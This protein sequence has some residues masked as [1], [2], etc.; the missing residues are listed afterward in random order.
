[1]GRGLSPATH[2]VIWPIVTRPPERGPPPAKAR[3]RA[4]SGSSGRPPQP[5]TYGDRSESIGFARRAR[6][7]IPPFLT[8]QHSFAIQS[9]P[10]ARPATNARSSNGSSGSGASGSSGAAARLSIS[11]SLGGAFR[12]PASASCWPCFGAMT[13]TWLNS[14]SSRTHP[15]VSGSGT[16]RPI[17]MRASSGGALGPL[18]ATR[19]GLRAINV[20]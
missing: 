11:K 16:R 20:V 9:V 3:I 5:A 10:T 1:V 18:E 7:R 6:A 2:V 13:L 17:G 15:I 12:I 14:R 4:N 19:R 8:C